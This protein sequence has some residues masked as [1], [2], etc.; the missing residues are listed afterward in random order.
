MFPVKIKIDEITSTGIKSI[1]TMMNLSFF[2]N[3]SYE[4][5]PKISRL[6]IEKMILM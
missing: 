2:L 4:Q 6:I 1:A 3:N 5:N